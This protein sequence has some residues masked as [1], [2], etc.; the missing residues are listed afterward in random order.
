MQLSKIKLA[1]FKSFVDPTT[2]DFPSNLIGIVGPNGCGK[3]NVIDAVRWVMGESSAK[4]LR[5]ESMA[6]VIF[7]GSSARKPV[8]Q[9][10][11]ELIFDNC[12]GRIGGQYAQY[13]EIS[14]KRQV[15]RDGHSQY[16][17]NGTKCRR[18]DITDIF[19]GTGLGPR[20]YSIIEQGM[21]SRLIEARPEDLRVYLEEAAG[22]SKYKERRKE[23]EKR[24]R[25]TR[26]NLD[27]LQD[28][29]DEIEK[30]L[31]KLQRQ[32]KTAERY[33]EFRQQERKIRAELLALRYQAQDTDNQRFQQR[34]KEQETALE[35]VVAEQRAIEAEI[36]KGRSELISENDV[37]NEV[38]GR[39]YGLGAD[40]A[41]V[42][43][44][45]QHGKSNRQRQQ[46]ELTQMEQAWNELLAHIKHDGERLQELMDNLKQREPE[47]EQLRVAEQTSGDALRQVEQAMQSW[48]TEWEDYNKRAAEPAQRAQ[49][50][51]TRI[52]HL[53]RQLK[54]LQEQ[55]AKMEAEQ[56]SLQGEDLESLLQDLL[57]Q[58]GEAEKDSQ[59]LDEKMVALRQ[60]IDEARKSRHQ[61]SS[62][63]DE[64]RG[65]Q[66]DLRGRKTSLDALQQAALGQSNSSISHWLDKCGLAQAP[67]LAQQIQVE[68]GWEKAV[69]T[70]LGFYLE[71][72]CVNDINKLS[73]S[74][75]ELDEGVLALFDTGTSASS[76]TTPTDA[77][78]L[79]DLVQAPWSM[80]SLLGGVYVAED[81]AQA[82]ALRS[83]L[84]AHESV[85][86]RQG[87]WLSAGWLRV[88]R[89]VDEKAGVLER[90]KEITSL[91]TQIDEQK[92]LVESQ[93]QI[94]EQTQ[95]DIQTS[96]RQREDLQIKVNQA[97]R[98]VSELNAQIN[99][100]RSRQEQ[101][102]KRLDNLSTDSGELQQRQTQDREALAQA[103]V[104]LQQALD[105]M[106]QLEQERTIFQ[107]RREQLRE[108]LEQSRSSAQSDRDKAHA[109]ALNIGSMK[110]SH[111]AIEQGLGRMQGQRNH[112]QTRRDDLRKVLDESETPLQEQERDL[113][114]KLQLRSEV[115]AELVVARRKV[116]ST[117]HDLRNNEQARGQK[118]QQV[119]VT[120]DQLAQ[121]RMASQES[122]VRAKTLLEQ[123]VET[124]FEL[125]TLLETMP[126][127][128]ALD[129]WE[130]EAERLAQ[131]IQRLG[132]I[133]LAAIDEFQEESER[134]TY[135]DAQNA[136]LVEALETLEE[137]IHKIDR[138]TRTRFKE[139]FDK[140]NIGL[141]AMF[142]R[143]FGGGH[144]YLELTGD[145]LLDTGVTVMA[146]PPGKRNSTIHLL[147]GGEK[148]LTAV[149]MVFAIFELNPSPFCM[150]DEVDA[151]LD[152]ANV[153][154]FCA[155]VKEMSEHVQF[156]FITHNKITMELAHQLSGVTMSEPGV[157]RLVTV[158][159]AE[160]TKIIAA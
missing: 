109:I 61:H 136:D 24:I 128:A 5:G 37:L 152:E 105:A 8:G 52:D 57:Q 42:E 31:E 36:E 63:L 83:S 118:E 144:A 70:V 145:D 131:R 21:I 86:T 16:F 149:A 60:H 115:E 90:E 147:S 25:H 124:D 142:P 76:I 72:V 46:Q 119:Q 43:E 15:T 10:S 75:N 133:N 47:L 95:L 69:E 117:E 125:E 157:S 38:Q 137:A 110:T 56:E 41:R 138:E 123:I 9:A 6:D 40:I 100:R 39:F 88:T 23:T 77:K 104:N 66:Q 132:P 92:Q 150:L 148:A 116:E 79:S 2:I 20:S 122:V 64:A 96:E 143:L 126:E 146:R 120:R 58:Q 155:M 68:S 134:K 29:I 28:L 48:Q 141:Q 111:E 30:Q 71:A 33:K 11:I 7:N 87:I 27:R 103:Q 67:R 80:S 129:K 153:G 54:Q 22:I 1:G 55:L 62:Q 135:L 108:Q 13:N 35:A 14:I 98:H 85:I 19:L 112:L 82:L 34:I 74:L 151:P 49:V 121:E 127:D 53:E 45:I 4:H 44:T 17:L 160:A 81:L 101:V 91:A 99:A 32:S 130:A 97:H 113:E 156:I 107:Q 102:S 154:R 73:D 93:T 139:T 12:E 51:R 84:Q 78:A 140:V 65:K 106:D 26:D 94:L 159:I 3:S 89:D 50:E 114:Q 18:R 59:G 158:D